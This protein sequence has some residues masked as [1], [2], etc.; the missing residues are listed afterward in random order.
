MKYLHITFDTNREWKDTGL[1]CYGN[2]K[3]VHAE[4]QSFCWTLLVTKHPVVGE[5]CD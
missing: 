2:A 3:E 1:F 4:K 5:E